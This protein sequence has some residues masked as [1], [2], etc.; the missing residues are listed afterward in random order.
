M[1]LSVKRSASPATA[2]LPLDTLAPGS[3]ARIA[4][5]PPEGDL[6]LR[7]MEM[8]FLPGHEITRLAAAPGGDP[9][10][11]LVDG[12]Q[13]ALRREIAHGIRVTR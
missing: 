10:I 7:L 2:D 6:S 3:P 8:G 4:S 11:F 5:L 13:I 9:V 12:S 1:Q